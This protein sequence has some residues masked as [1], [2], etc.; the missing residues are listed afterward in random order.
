ME[1]DDR[2]A[3]RTPYERLSVW[4]DEATGPGWLLDGAL[5][6]EA[7][8]THMIKNRIAPTIAGNLCSFSPNSAMVCRAEE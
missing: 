3:A 7:A 2:E 6:R 1:G 5:N 8:R 4:Q